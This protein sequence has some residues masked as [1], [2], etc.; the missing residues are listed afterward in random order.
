M[1]NKDIAIIGLSIGL[2]YTMIKSKNIRRN[3]SIEKLQ[4]FAVSVEL[5]LENLQ[6][7]KEIKRLRRGK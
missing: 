1:N 5:A 6:L 4:L 3:T 7:E 2:V